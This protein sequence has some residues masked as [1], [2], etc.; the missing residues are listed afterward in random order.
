M[1]PENDGTPTSSVASESHPAEIGKNRRGSKTG[2]TEKSKQ[3][4][5]WVHHVPWWMKPII[6]GFFKLTNTICHRMGILYLSASIAEMVVNGLELVVSVLAV[7]VIR[8]RQIPRERWVGVSG[9]SFI[10]VGIY[11]YYDHRE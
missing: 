5:K 2:L 10:M 9:F 8:T 3:A 4:V 1:T 6:P 7:I 11:V